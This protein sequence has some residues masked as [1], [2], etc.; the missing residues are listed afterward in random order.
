MTRDMNERRETIV[1]LVNEG[2]TVS[3][4]QIKAALPH[5]SEMTLRTDL[6]TLDAERR[7]VRIHGG[8]RSV[9]YVIGT[10]DLLDSRSTRNVAAKKTIAA[11]AAALV[12]PE[13]SVFLDSGTTTTRL[14]AVLPNAHV[15]A[16]TNS[17]T[18]AGELARLDEVECHVMGG[19]L[20]P[21]SLCCH[22]SRTIEEIQGHHFDMMFLGVTSLHPEEG[23][24]CGNDEEARLK[25]ACIKRAERV[26]ALMDSSKVGP[27]GT[28][29]VCHLD[30]IDTIVCDDE[31]DEGVRH[32][33]EAAGIE[34]I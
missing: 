34:L 26:V 30:L 8:A 15:L 3:F 22:G 1:R 27:A 11:K 6:K 12:A 2:G 17:L 32:G 10:D 20:N 19:R 24:F 28:F 31:L 13:S 21:Q 23:V 4:A 7:I 18:V 16:F 25:A 33:L 9:G 14:A 29:H 5:V